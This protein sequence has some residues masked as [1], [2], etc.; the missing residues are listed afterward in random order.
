ML[1]SV[2]YKLQVFHAIPPDDRIAHRKFART[3][4]DEKHDK[5]N[6]FPRKIILSD[7]AA[8]HISGKVHRQNVHF[9]GSEHSHAAVAHI[10]D[11]P[12]VNIQCG[13]LQGNLIGS[14]FCAKAA[15]TS[16]SFLDLLRNL[17]SFP[18]GDT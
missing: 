2:F 9:W 1:A 18:I 6:E 7:E 16:T 17:G 5:Y 15:V 12:T 14:F 4:L 10:R 8:F 13:L 3:I 11:S